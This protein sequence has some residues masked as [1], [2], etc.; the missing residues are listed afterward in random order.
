MKMKM[1]MK[2][3]VILL[4]VLW[5]IGCGE[6]NPDTGI[7]KLPNFIKGSVKSSIATLSLKNIAITANGD[8][9]LSERIL[10]TDKNGNFEFKDVENG[11]FVLLAK[12]NN[13]LGVVENIKMKGDSIKISPIEMKKSCSITGKV[14]GENN[15]KAFIAGIA[16]T[17]I[18][19]NTYKIDGVPKGNI[20]VA[21]SNG[22]TV[23]IMP[24]K[25]NGNN[26]EYKLNSV[27]FEKN[28]SDNSKDFYFYN[29]KL[30]T[31]CIKSFTDSIGNVNTYYPDD[32]G[33]L[34][35]INNTGNFSLL[36]D[37]FEDNNSYVDFASKEKDSNDYFGDWYTFDDSSSGGNSKILSSFENL[38]TI[39]INE[40]DNTFLSF[41]VLFKS[42]IPNPY[43]GF[44]CNL[45]G[46]SIESTDLSNLTS[47]QFKAKGNCT[48]NVSFIPKKGYITKENF[49]IFQNTIILKNQ[50]ET[51]SLPVEN[52]VSKNGTKV[53]SS[54]YTWNDVK[55]E[56]YLF[57]FFTKGTPNDTAIVEI[58]DIYFN[59][60]KSDNI[61]K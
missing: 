59:G 10:E 21:V 54:G 50:W 7:S 34:N 27:K 61:F 36:V 45:K 5:I 49:D 48:I 6:I 35:Q 52:F 51:I 17:N 19:N 60:I 1:K 44:G 12:N 20:S 15:L 37:N 2:I 47:I 4:G 18:V 41:K 33:K 22:K 23:N 55:D 26:E 42:A 8:S 56:I 28:L 53:T 14:T 32:N 11:N 58:D 9:I 3:K 30:N 24:I 25:I 57:Q 39:Y 46:D 13:E 40:D 16:S 29:S 38:K 43:S 31:Y